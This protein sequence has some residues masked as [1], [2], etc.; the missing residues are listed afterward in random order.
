[1]RVKTLGELN[2]TLLLYGGIYSNFEAFIKMMDVAD[3]LNIKPSSR[4]S[5]GDLVA[6]CADGSKIVSYFMEHNLTSIAG[7]CEKQLAQNALDCGCGYDEASICSLLS[8]AWYQH[9]NQDIDANA[10]EWMAQLPDYILFTH[11]KKRF[12]MIHG[13][14]SDISKFIWSVSDDSLFKAEIDQLKSDFGDIDAV[15]ASHSGIPFLKEIDGVTWVN[16]GAIGMPAHDG[17]NRTHYVILEKGEVRFERLTYDY[18]KASQRMRDVGL[19]QGYHD[20]LLTGYW[21]SEDTLPVELRL[22]RDAL[23]SVDSSAR[24]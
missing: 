14:A 18:Q 21:P 4:L 3:D 8:R 20:A 7:N 15:I 24:G 22:S 2:D 11:H 5:N 1:M 19:T 13:G 12:V 23:S 17:D 10:R 9:L 16:T 6:Y